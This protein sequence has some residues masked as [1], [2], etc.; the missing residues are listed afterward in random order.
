MIFGNNFHESKSNPRKSRRNSM[1]SESLQNVYYSKLRRHLRIELLEARTLLAAG[2]DIVQ[3]F[4]L[5][6]HEQS[7]DYEPDSSSSIPQG[8]IIGANGSFDVRSVFG[9]APTRHITNDFSAHQR[10]AAGELQLAMP[11]LTFSVDSIFGVPSTAM[12][13]LGFLTAESENPPEAI[14]RSFFR[15][16]RAFFGLEPSDT[17]EILVSAQ[18]ISSLTDLSHVYLQQ[19]FEGLDVFGGVA[20]VSLNAA[21]QVLLVGN[22]F[23]PDVAGSLNASKPQITAEQAVASAAR[24]LNLDV[25]EPLTALQRDG[26]ADQLAV[27]SGGGISRDPIPVKLVIVPMKRGESRLAW[28]T[29]INMRNGQDWFEMNVDA[30]TSEVLVRYNWTAYDSYRVFPQPLESPQDGVGLPGSHSVVTNPANATASPFGWHDT[31]GVAGA[32]FTDTR[33]NNVFAQEDRDGNNT[34]GARPT[35]ATNDYD[36]A[37]APTQTPLENVDEATVNLFY[38]NNII[39]DVMALNGF[40]AAAGNFQ[41]NNY[42]ASGLSGDPVQADAQ[43]AAANGAV[44]NANFSTPRDGLSPRMQMFEFSV[45]TPRRDSD[46]DAGIIV[47][48]YGHGISN[49]LVGGPANVTALQGIQS[50]G[51]GE[52]WSDWYSL[53]FTTKPTDTST[54]SYPLGTYLFGQPSTGSGIRRFPYSTNQTV[55]P[56]TYDDIDAGQADV[57]CPGGCSQVH[58]VGEIWASALWDLY[59]ILVN[60]DGFNANLYTGTGGN[61]LALKLVTEG[62]K[63]IPASPTMLQARDGILAADLA[64]TGGANLGQIWRAFAGR[65]MGF[66]A[67]DGGNHNSVAVVEA[68]DVPSIRDGSVDF[69]AASYQIGDAVTVIVRDLDLVA[70]GSINVTVTSSSGD[71]ETVVL[72]RNA[73]QPGVLRGSIITAAGTPSADGRL[74]VVLTGQ[75]GVTYLDANDGAGGVNVVNS[76]TAEIRKQANAFVQLAPRGGLQFLSRNNTGAINVAG[77]QNGFLF[78]VEGGQNISVIVTPS[79]PAA[80]VTVQLVGRSGI[81]SA[82]AAGQTAVLPPTAIGTSGELA[83]IISSN[84]A[85]AYQFEIGRNLSREVVDT[86]DGS[87]LAIDSSIIDVGTRRYAV[88]GNARPILPGLGFTQSNNPGL[89]VDISTTGTP[90]GLADDD[91]ATITTTVGNTF[92]P[93]GVVRIGNNGGIIAGTGAS[94]S[95]INQALPNSG[96]GNAL[97]PFWD[98]IDGGPGNVYWE[99]R[100]IVG[101]NTLIVQW[102]NRPHFDVGGA[103]TF[104]LQ[105]FESGPIVARYVY[106]D[107]TIGNPLYDFG[108]SATIGY[109]QNATTASQFSFNSPRLANGDVLELRVI[110][111]VPDI[112]EYTIDLT[113]RVGRAID[114]VLAGLDGAKFSGELLELL[115]PNG[116]VLATALTDPVQS[117]VNVTNFDLGILGFSVPVGGIYT[118]RFTSTSTRSQYDIVVTDSLLYDSEPNN[119][120]VTDSLRSLDGTSTALGAVSF[121]A[122]GL[123]FFTARSIFDAAAPGL[124][125]EDFE[126]G[127]ATLESVVTCN[128][129]LNS[130][131]NDACFT[132]GEILPGIEIQDNPGPST[133][134]LFILGAWL[135]GNP[136]IVTGASSSAESTDLRFPSNDVFSVGMDVLSNSPGVVAVGITIFGL[137]GAILSTSTV[138]A[139]T[140]GKFWG[141]TSDQ[142]ITRVALNSTAFDF[143]DNVA[144]GGKADIDQYKITLTA[145]E[146]V[147]LATQTMFTAPATTPPNTLDPQLRLIDPNGTTVVAADQNSLDGRDS[148]LV[149]SVTST[150]VYTIEVSAESGSGEYI[151]RRFVDNIPPSATSFTRKTPLMSPTNADTLVFLA[152]FSEAVTGVAAADFAVAGTNGTISVTQVTPSTYDITI[153]GGNLASLNGTVGLNFNSPT[154][155]D[156]FGNALPNT[157]PP[158]DQTYVVDNA[159]PTVTNIIV[160]GSAWGPAFIDAI[161]GGGTGAGNGL[162]YSLTR[163]LILPSSGI[164]RIYIQ[165]S[166]PVVGFSAARFALLGVNVANYVGLLSSVTYNALNMRAEIQLSTIVN[167]DNLRIGV[168]DTVT[169]ASINSLDG[170]SSGVAGGILD[171]RFNVLVGDANGDG[172]VNG[173]D[174]PAFAG[175][176][177]I[178]AG[179]AGYNA[180]AD[181]N[182]DGSVNGGDLPFFAGNFNQSLPSSEP[183]AASFGGGGGSGL[184]A[185]Q[186]SFADLFFSELDDEDDKLALLL[187]DDRVLL[188]EHISLLDSESLY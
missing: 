152:T 163:G 125:V 69:D 127:S 20:N 38:W 171:F 104:Q 13:G 95:P 183:G 90:L 63:L 132:P 70:I 124:P 46:N 164:N 76:D 123:V 22:S 117:G 81:I 133:G 172:S 113:G 56:L 79:N 6:S 144:F 162:G 97:L 18:S 94:L 24:S 111:P 37:F 71:S 54:D 26:E 47:H 60:R 83:I 140:T 135:I 10:A 130:A 68:F 61:N 187:E 2:T 65:G 15:D 182:A 84:I 30:V 39:H 176:F 8:A 107:V 168:A 53:V 12:N 138:N 34:G 161:D 25:E 118:I 126:D 89:F 58:N 72:T 7:W 177:N 82:P 106:P 99:E 33:G 129:P 45:T 142:V 35:S 52:G 112:D 145:G 149:F 50:G 170:D 21:G 19:T 110:V 143:V 77:G 175:A 36:F 153:T 44:N 178:S 108:A 134:G 109:Q 80:T 5:H 66:S 115:S 1:S 102:H 179:F 59:W 78:F 167:R 31:N 181:W 156:L 119:D 148:R 188:E 146:R 103:V 131:S 14:A 29:V 74:Q 101:V 141:V 49:R 42:G 3:S 174:L 9:T 157:E 85:T 184:R 136:S 43:D 88:L 121:K 100:Q 87:E 4:S 67:F 137:G 27:F 151:V 139:T 166:E 98:D 73:I 122:P 40:D 93:V 180:R 159:A 150:G 186:G 96:F 105:L 62:L 16:N 51:M 86:A 11:G 64:M 173:G 154:I 41:S 165:F 91:Q 160:S 28:N 23:A 55:D 120:L 57:P 169:D 128:A 32:E 17:S 92:F 158:T 155:A 114:V 185:P 48:E 75:I 147:G 116:S